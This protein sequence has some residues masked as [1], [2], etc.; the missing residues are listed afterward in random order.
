MGLLDDLTDPQKL[1]GQTRI[2]CTVCLL[3]KALDPK[4]S[5]KLAVV[6]DDP[7]VTKSAIARIL[8]DNGYKIGADAI[9]RHARRQCSRN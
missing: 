1:R 3:L 6:I 8:Q 2:Q 4:E 9:T 5:E 7:T